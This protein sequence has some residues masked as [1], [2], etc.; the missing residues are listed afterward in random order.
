MTEHI[1]A[2]QRIAGH[3]AVFEPPLQRAVLPRVP[4]PVHQQREAFL[5]AELRGLRFFLLLGK[6]K[7]R[8][9]QWLQRRPVQLREQR[10]RLTVTPRRPPACHFELASPRITDAAFSKAISLSVALTLRLDP[11]ES[12]RKLAAWRNR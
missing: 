5:E 9:R 11:P 4:L 10:G 8:G 12:L 2:D 1:T 7:T 6:L 3:P